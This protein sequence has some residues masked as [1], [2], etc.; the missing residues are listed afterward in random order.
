MS[1]FDDMM[2]AGMSEAS[3]ALGTLDFT[4][5]GRSYKGVH[6]EYTSEQQVEMEGL[7]LNFDATLVCERPQFRLVAKPLQRTLVGKLITLE[8]IAYRVEKVHVDSASITLGLRI[9]RAR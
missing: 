1:L 7:L 6:N 5:D 8:G 3:E 4:I 2:E 9:D